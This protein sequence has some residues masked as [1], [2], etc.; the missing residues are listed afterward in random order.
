MILFCLGE[1]F[2]VVRP[3][4]DLFLG[5]LALLI[6]FSEDEDEDGEFEMFCLGDDFAVAQPLLDLCFGGVAFLI[7][8][9][10]DEDEDDDED[11]DEFDLSYD[12]DFS[13]LESCLTLSYVDLD[14]AEY[15][16]SDELPIAVSDSISD[17]VDDATPEPLDVVFS[18]L[19][20]Q[21]KIIW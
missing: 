17:E 11:K 3:L 8:S 1:D 14:K 9:S 5:G 2:A 16:L 19:L 10:E 6:S 12:P 18:L 7:S 4:L 20:T 21:T 13:L 15:E